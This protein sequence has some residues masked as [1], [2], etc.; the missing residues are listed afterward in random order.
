MAAWLCAAAMSG[1]GTQELL[2]GTKGSVLFTAM[3]ALTTPGEPVEL[4]AQLR[5]GDLLRGR[6]GYAVRFYRGGKLFKVAETD[7]DGVAAVAFT[8][9]APGD[10]AFEAA[11]APL[12]LAEEPPAP[13]KLTV[14]CRAPET[15]IAVVDLDKTVVATGFHTVLVGSAEPMARSQEVLR[16][17]SKTHTVVYLT[18]RPDYFSI[19]SK[20]WLA[21]H[22]YPPGPLLLS[23]L[24][25]FLKGSGAFKSEQLAELQKQF[26]KIEIGIGDKV[27]DAEAYHAR[28][29]KSFLIL[30]VPAGAEDTV[31]DALADELEALDAS[32]QVVTDWT[33][34]ERGL[35]GG[36]AFGRAAMQKRLRA[37]AAEARATADPGAKKPAPKQP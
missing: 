35:F 34:V 16:R 9:T 21:E 7:D 23:T 17:L 8:P 22:G 5:A 33:Q 31:Y 4:R 24:G 2:L 25:G 6:P 19:K 10:F 1:C 3:D 29:L 36:G 14:A 30:Q 26:R 20:A 37:L 11:L 12:G 32:V 18:H 15:P 28:G 13:R 27:S